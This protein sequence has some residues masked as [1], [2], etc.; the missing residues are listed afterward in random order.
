MAVGWKRNPGIPV[1]KSAASTLS[2]ATMKFSVGASMP[3]AGIP[4]AS[5]EAYSRCNVAAE[6]HE[7][8]P[9]DQAAWPTPPDAPVLPCYRY[10]KIVGLLSFNDQAQKFSVTNSE[11]KWRLRVKSLSSQ[12]E[13]CAT[14]M[15]M[16][17][18]DPERDTRCV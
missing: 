6:L 16:I 17:A 3:L 8:H 1:K 12:P 18:D 10:A 9:F 4:L 7:G 5:L 15:M 2:Q 11:A 14:M 13:T